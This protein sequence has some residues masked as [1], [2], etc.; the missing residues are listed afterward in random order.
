MKVVKLLGDR[1]LIKPLKKEKEGQ[2]KSG[3]LLPEMTQ[4][5]PQEGEVIAIGKGKVLEDGSI[6]PMEIKVGDKVFYGKSVGMEMDVE[7]EKLLVM[8]EGEILA[9]V[10]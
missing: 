9:I 3:I 7:G 2:T 5:R 6:S 8:H 4:E 10:K 1:L